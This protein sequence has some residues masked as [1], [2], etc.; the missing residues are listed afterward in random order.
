MDCGKKK[1]EERREKIEGKKKSELGPQ[2][3]A[4]SIFRANAIAW[5]VRRRGWKERECMCY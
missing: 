4:F 5:F 2:R 3:Y 1:R